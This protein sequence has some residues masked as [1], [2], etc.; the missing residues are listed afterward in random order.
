[1]CLIINREPN[2]EIPYEKFKTAIV[3]NP[4]GFGFSYP[5]FQGNLK[6]YRSCEEPDPEQLYRIIN[7]ELI[8]TKLMLHLRYTTVGATI[9]RNSH[10]FPILEKNTDGIDLRMA[11]N[12]TLGKYRPKSQSSESDTRLF[13]KTFVRPLFKRLAKGLDPEELMNDEF[14]KKLLED[15]LT[16]SSVLTFIDGN[17][18]S[19]VCNETGNGG[20]QE[21]KW[22]YSNKYS[23]DP[24]HRI[25]A[26]TSVTYPYNYHQHNQSNSSGTTAKPA[27]S[28]ALKAS[29]TPKFTS[30]YDLDVDELFS[31]GD[32]TIKKLVNE[33]PTH[34]QL[35]IKE[36]LYELQ[37]TKQKLSRV[38]NKLNK[39]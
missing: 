29:N 8:D 30:V 5:D 21:E 16:T 28:L 13:V 20:K 37:K 27:T 24:K 15:Q 34:S 36:L 11:H 19:L 23:F 38:T 22:Y 6:T 10:P 12:G 3:N 33:H 26:T 35:L 32:D 1:M 25:P 39:G 17:G 7:E 9:L 4:H 18:N 14:T 2:F 31:L